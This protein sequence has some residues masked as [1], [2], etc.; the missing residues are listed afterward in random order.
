MAHCCR[1][2]DAASESDV[3]VGRASDAELVSTSADSSTI[4]IS[5]E[6]FADLP[7]GTPSMHE[8]EEDSPILVALPTHDVERG[9]PL[10]ALISRLPQRGS[11]YLPRHVDNSTGRPI[12]LPNATSILQ[13][14][15]YFGTGSGRIVEQYASR[16]LAVSSFWGVAP[17]ACYH[18]L[19]ILGPPSCNDYGECPH[20]CGGF[21]AEQ[22]WATNPL[23]PIPEGTL[24]VYDGLL[25]RVVDGNESARANRTVKLN[26]VQMWKPAANGTLRPCT[27]A[28]GGA[29]AYPANCLFGAAAEGEGLEVPRPSVLPSSAGV[30]CPLK[31][32]L[33]D[34]VQSEPTSVAFGE[35]Y[36]FLAHDQARSY[37]P[38]T[39]FIEVGVDNPVYLLSIEVGM[40]RGMGAVVSIRVRPTGSSEWLSIYEGDAFVASSQQHARARR[41]MRWAPPVCRPQRRISEVRLELDTTSETGIADWNYIDYVLMIGAPHVPSS[42]TL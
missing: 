30:W 34:G 31:R 37:P 41:Y 33:F 9:A 35:Q 32:G 40:P 19:N 4:L 11:L 27:I 8:T 26:M 5:V 12:L 18:P 14:F 3:A 16:V 7:W 13:P 23:L 38:F 15:N 17:Y 24:V 2:L 39:E 6:A 36:G 28:P 10:D 29:I 22:C 20:T 21:P 25:A 1:Q 42:L